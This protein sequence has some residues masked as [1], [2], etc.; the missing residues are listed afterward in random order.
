MATY[1]AGSSCVIIM[2]IG[3]KCE[4]FVK[5]LWKYITEVFTD[6]EYIFKLNFIFKFK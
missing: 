1:N 3:A 4:P 5:N 6:Q 2:Y